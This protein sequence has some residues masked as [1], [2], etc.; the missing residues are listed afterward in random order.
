MVGF[1]EFS[2]RSGRTFVVASEV[3]D[4]LVYPAFVPMTSTASGRTSGRNSS[5]ANAGGKSEIMRATSAF[6]WASVT[7]GLIRASA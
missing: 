7:P 6:A 3:R 1:G 2:V 5:R 4:W